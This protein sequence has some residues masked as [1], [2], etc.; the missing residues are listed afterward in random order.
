[1]GMKRGGVGLQK[2]DAREEC[3]LVRVKVG[4]G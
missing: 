1:M 2:G 4:D 3:T